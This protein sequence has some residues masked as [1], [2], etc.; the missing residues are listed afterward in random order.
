MFRSKSFLSKSIDNC[1]FSS[2]SNPLP[3]REPL[4]T[5]LDKKSVIRQRVVNV[6]NTRIEQQKE[7]VRLGFRHFKKHQMPRLTLPF[8][9]NKY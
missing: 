2:F 9:R 7:T 4:I 5:V 3:D 1:T 8:V 6:I